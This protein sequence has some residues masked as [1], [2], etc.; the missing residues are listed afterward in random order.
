MEDKQELRELLERLDQSNRQQAR[1]ARW[2]CMFSILSAVCVIGL[3]VLV[4]TLMPQVQELSAQ[5]QVVLSN[6]TQ[7]TD[8][9]ADMDL[10]AMIENVDELVVT[11]QS[12]VDQ[13]M[14][15]LNQIDFDT[16]NQAISDLS[17]VVEP[18]ASFFNIFH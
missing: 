5:T 8:Q 7:V 1:Y 12:G 2:Q 16:L 11:S 13:A 15:K 6:L 3:F 9:L 10:G 17:D 18:L 14:K 4:Y